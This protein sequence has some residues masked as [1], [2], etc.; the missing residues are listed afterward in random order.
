MYVCV[1]VVVVAVCLC[2]AASSSSLFV[3]VVLVVVVCLCTAARHNKEASN[4][5]DSS[6]IE[7]VTAEYNDALVFEPSDDRMAYTIRDPLT[8]GL[9]D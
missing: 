8:S 1:V 6:L 3:V 9:F 5:V 2:T 4:V 7:A